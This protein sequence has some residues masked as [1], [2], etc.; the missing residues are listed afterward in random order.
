MSGA[1]RSSPLRRVVWVLC[2]R[3][4]IVRVS[5]GLVWLVSLVF[6]YWVEKRR[7]LYGFNARFLITADREM[8]PISPVASPFHQIGWVEPSCK[9]AFV[10][11]VLLML[12]YS[13]TLSTKEATQPRL[14]Q[15]LRKILAKT[16][17]S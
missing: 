4:C 1:G 15:I 8:V 12:R 13:I 11:F 14:A 6:H 2:V 17:R 16:P 3:S 7:C 10:R 9:N 5:V